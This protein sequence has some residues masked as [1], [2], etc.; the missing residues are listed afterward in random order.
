MLDVVLQLIV[1]FMMLVHFSTRLEGASQEIRLPVAPA[2]LPTAELAFDR[3]AVSV[4]A[5]GRLLAGGTA[6]E[7]PAASNWWADQARQRRDGL[8]LLAGQRETADLATLVILRA[9]RGAPYGAVR[10]QLALAQR[11]GF[12]RFTLVVLKEEPR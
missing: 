9:D 11:Q 2:A 5:A 3:L 7:G 12:S 1:F 8:R 6:I 10:E 4:D